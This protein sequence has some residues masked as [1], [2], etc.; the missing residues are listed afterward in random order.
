MQ[1]NMSKPQN[2]QLPL[3][4]YDC[5]TNARFGG[6]IG[7]LVFDANLLA[8]A[9]M[10]A[11]AKE[12]NAPVTGFVTAIDVNAV[13]VKFF[14]PTAEIPMCSHVTIGLYTYLHE[15]GLVGGEGGKSPLLKTSCGS[16]QVST[17]VLSGGEIV[18]MMNLGSVVIE[19]CGVSRE[20]VADALRINQLAIRT[21]FPIEIGATGLRH[22]F[23][24]LSDLD[25]LENMQPDFSALTAL[26]EQLS[27]ETIAPFS[28]QT[29][30][31]G[32]TFHCR[33]FCPVLGVNE[34]PASGTTNSAL[35][36]YLVGNRL[37][38]TADRNGRTNILAEQG[39][40]L[41]R[42]SVVQI[43]I[44]M[45]NSKITQIRVGGSAILSIDGV[46]NA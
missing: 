39:Y 1:M 25:T 14:M 26:S 36:G 40:K 43:E 4:I 29:Y 45:N 23:V 12:I 22:L 9:E 5:F 13:Q 16:T 10:Q 3:K 31:I 27:V 42:P 8:D 33:D 17:T 34:V 15:Q 24:P 20:L 35:S 38:N 32:N 11:M 46:I 21:D 41:G 18:V 37:V 2:R 7:G 30:V 28:M 6:N 44:E 19:K